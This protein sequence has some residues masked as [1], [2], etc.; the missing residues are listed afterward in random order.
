MSGSVH[1]AV[2]TSECMDALAVKP[3]GRY[4]DATLGGGTHTAEMLK[5]SA[6]GGNVLSFDVDPAA[7]KRAQERF[8][9]EKK[10]WKGVEANFRTLADVARQEGFVPLDGILIDLGFSSD[11]LS[12]PTKGLSFQVEGPL[13][14]RLGPSADVTA[15]HI[16]NGWR[17]RELADLFREYGEENYARPIAKAIV[18][19]RKSETIVTT[20]QLADIIAA[21]V[22]GS[23]EHGRINPATRTFQALRIAV[24]DELNALRDAIDGAH[25][26]LAEGGR[27]A[28]ISF[29]SLEDR[30][31]KEAFKDTE[32]W[33]PLTK[34]PMIP[35]DQEARENPRS[36]SAKLRVAVRI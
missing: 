3:G 6:P 30:I 18:A 29:H 32:R 31:V 19:A 1:I 16:V 21:A 24:N 8:V 17:E 20:T 27:L 11:Q 22:P 7:L 9:R 33:K 15:A 4:L 35:T 25:E 26:V 10:S 13:D 36:R 23:Y 28:I 5:R 2:M 34:K 14:M 12:D